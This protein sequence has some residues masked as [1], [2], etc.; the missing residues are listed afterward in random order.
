MVRTRL[1]DAFLAYIFVFMAVISCGFVVTSVLRLRTEE[2]TG[3]AEAVLA[4]PVSRTTWLAAT[5]GCDVPRRHHVDRPHGVGPCR[6]L[7]ASARGSGTRSC[8]RSPASSS[9]LPGTLVLGAFAVALHGLL[10]RATGLA[11]AAVALVALQVM[12]GQL[13][14][15]PDAVQALSPYSHL[16][17]VPVDDFD[18]VPFVLLLVVAAA[19]VAAG[20]VGIP[21]TRRGQRLT[22]RPLTVVAT[23]RRP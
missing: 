4:T 7:R 8:H 20:L 22:R 14:D 12:L 17:A 18:V 13:L 15:L 6:R 9:Y 21:P 1:V 5:T 19:L 23:V 16:A 2:E 11:W 10:P 3:R